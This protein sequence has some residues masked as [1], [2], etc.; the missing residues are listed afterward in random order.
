MADVSDI[1]RDEFRD[2]VAG[3]RPRS[4]LEVGSGEGAFLKTLAGDVPRLCGLDP[5]PD[6]IAA[7]KAQGFEAVL[8]SAERLPFADGEFDVV[9]FSFTP[10]HLADWDKALG[11]AFRVARHSI[12]ILDV[13]YDETIADQRTAQALDRWLK[14]IDRRTG[15]VH[16][17]T[18]TP[19]AM[20]APVIGRRDVTFDYLCRRV[21][22]PANIDETLKLGSDYLAK[23][24]ND[25]ALKR[26]FDQ[27]IAAAHRDGMTQEGALLMTIEKR[28]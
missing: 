16:M 11:E 25:N 9:A 14:A 23:V 3:G 21:A 27:I 26:E 10:H 6:N 20:L 24:G 28:R 13:W 4:L 15:M 2:R 7:L 1:Y 19:G 8:G 5:N 22:E 12:E 17:D 18:L